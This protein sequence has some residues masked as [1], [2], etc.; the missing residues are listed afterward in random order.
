MQGQI[1]ESAP[2]ALSDPAQ[3]NKQ[4]SLAILALAIAAFAIGT[5][6]FVIMGLLPQ[7]ATNLSV[8]IPSAGWLVSGYALGVAIGA[9][10][11]AMAT[12][13]LPRKTALI[14]LMAI[15]VIGNLFCALAA[16]YS[17]LMIARVI[18]A[19][20]HGAFFGIS[21]VVG[22]SLAPPGRKA[23]VVALIFTGL[24]L[25][26]VLGVPLGT[27]LGQAAGWRSTFWAVTGLGVITFISLITLLPSDK[28][29]ETSSIRRELS[30]LRE[31]R[32]WL[33]LTMT[34]LFSASMFVLFT[35]IAPILGEVTR[36]SP[37]GVTWVLLLI[38]VGMTIGGV[39][40][41]RLTDWRPMTSLIGGFI[42]M[43]ILEAL[44][45]WTSHNLVPASVTLFFWAL[46]SFCVANGLQMNVV[47]LGKEA[48]NLVSTMN[49]GA[50]NAGN[51]LGAWLGGIVIDRNFGWT[52]VPLTAAGV[53]IVA[54]LV[55]LFL[56]SLRPR[57]PEMASDEPSNAAC[58]TN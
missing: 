29:E 43:A 27:A 32:I 40:G 41:G 28:N 49:I 15:F 46:T 45:S 17:L 6:E 26:N 50:F 22:A 18:T 24:T 7:V 23:A 48:P 37:R 14:V 38:G 52:A 36:I 57:Q 20:C 11:M 31:G 2:A 56:A 42:A 53:A 54:L 25:A 10:I 35:Y 1:F 34:V 39:L 33:G 12:A 8:S 13:R 55:T 16:N 5:T 30:A 51:A 3:N 21:T 4:T 58:A 47:S 9:P 44:F 19:L